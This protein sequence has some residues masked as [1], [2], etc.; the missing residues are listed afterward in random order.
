MQS[1]CNITL[2]TGFVKESGIERCKKCN[3]SGRF[4]HLLAGQVFGLQH[5]AS[6]YQAIQ[7]WIRRE[8]GLPAGIFLLFYN[9][10]RKK[11]KFHFFCPE[12]LDNPVP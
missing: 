8:S 1:D 12:N 6:F 2:W 3:S 9:C 7:P 10:N 5:A 11:Y 4:V